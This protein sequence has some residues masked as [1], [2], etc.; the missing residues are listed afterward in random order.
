LAAPKTITPR[1]AAVRNFPDMAWVQ[2]WIER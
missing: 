2:S 1:P